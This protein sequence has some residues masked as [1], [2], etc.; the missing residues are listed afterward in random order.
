MASSLIFLA[1]ALAA[2]ALPHQPIARSVDACAAVD[3]IVLLLHAE[4]EADPFCSS[5]LHITPTT[6]F[7][8]ASSTPAPVW[9]TSTAVA[10]NTAFVTDTELFTSVYSTTYTLDITD[11]LVYTSEEAITDTATL[12]SI[13]T[14]FVTDTNTIVN[15]V[16]ATTTVR[17]PETITVE[18]TDVVTKVFTTTVYPPLAKRATSAPVPTPTLLRSIAA[19]LLSRGCSCLSLPTSTITATT[20]VVVPTKT[21]RINLL[22]SLDSYSN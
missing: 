21:V 9:V 8:T 11:V 14:T 13:T 6:H 17:V 3:A 15:D 7:V 12:T 2:A 10:T 22:A 4:S 1:F 19:S 5:L 16:I 20:T 18:Q